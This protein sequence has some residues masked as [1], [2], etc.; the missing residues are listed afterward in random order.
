MPM[1]MPY[2]HV[3]G[4]YV[5]TGVE[6]DTGC[7]LQERLLPLWNT[8]E[9]VSTKWRCREGLRQFGGADDGEA[10]VWT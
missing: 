3:S 9:L 8:T 7:M 2:C 5:P 4:D 1:P 6:I 10:L